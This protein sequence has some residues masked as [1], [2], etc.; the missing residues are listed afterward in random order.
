M[1]PRVVLELLGIGFGIGVVV[2]A[3]TVGYFALSEIQNKEMQ[4][5]EQETDRALN[6]IFKKCMEDEKAKFKVKGMN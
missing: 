3:A 4:R 6:D 1:E 5:L 2:G